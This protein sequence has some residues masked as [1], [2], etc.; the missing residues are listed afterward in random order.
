MLMTVSRPENDCSD[1]DDE[2]DQRHGQHQ[3]QH[4]ISGQIYGSDY[5]ATD[6]NGPNGSQKTAIS[7]R[8]VLAARS[9]HQARDQV[10]E[11]PGEIGG[12]DARDFQPNHCRTLQPHGER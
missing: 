10:R 4:E 6:V 2:H 8:F 5:H 11:C 1:H 12:S 3:C 9:P 7:K